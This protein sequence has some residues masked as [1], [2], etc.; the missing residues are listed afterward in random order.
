MSEENE[1]VYRLTKYNEGGFDVVKR[2]DRKGC[3]ESY[4][5]DDDC[6]QLRHRPDDRIVE[7]T[8]EEAEHRG[9]DCCSLCEGTA[10]RGGREKDS[11]VECPLCGEP[12]T[13]HLPNHIRRDCEAANPA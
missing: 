6:L 5:T 9:Y 8:R 1:T 7:T 10:D 13:D 12:T 2:G 11:T 3:P 4:H